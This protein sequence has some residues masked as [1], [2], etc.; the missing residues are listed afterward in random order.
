MVSGLINSYPDTFAVIYVHL[1]DDYEVP[2]GDAR[3]DFYGVT[4]I[5]SFWYDGLFDAWP[6][7]TY[8]SKFLQ[9]KD[10]PT[11]IT[12]LLFADG[13][14]PTF[15]ITAHVC[16]EPTGTARTMRI[17]MVQVLDHYPASP[18]Y[19][20]NCVMQGAPTQDITLNP[21]ECLDVT[22]TF[23]LSG[24]SL[25]DLN[26]VKFFAWAQEPLAS[27][28]AEVHQAQK[29]AWP[30]D[31]DCNG[32]SIPDSVDLAM[33]TSE[34]CNN[35]GIPDE[36]DTASGTS[37]DCNNNS[38]PDECEPD[39]NNNE[40]ADECDII[41]GTSCDANQ[42]LVPDECECLMDAD[43]DGTID[44]DDFVMLC[45]DFAACQAGCDADFDCDGASTILDLLIH[46]EAWGS[47]CP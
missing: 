6:I 29:M 9:R 19:Y 11:D 2:W 1:S 30:L 47:S 33:G 25:S 40:I 24:P 38:V 31:F 8:E 16:M 42:N 13:A 10:V 39:C 37:E 28:P 5:P 43:G 36:C 26:N 23:T 34:D 14:S 4:G 44:F 7:S 17:Y 32:N 27:G 22:Q 46:M 21:G 45:A 18:T 15:D 20:R 12:I 41:A 35:N 3:G